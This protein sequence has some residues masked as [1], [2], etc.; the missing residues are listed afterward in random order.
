MYIR[1]YIRTYVH[2]CLFLYA[3]MYVTTVSIIHF[4]SH[5]SIPSRPVLR[6]LHVLKNCADLLC[7]WTR[8]S[9]NVYGVHY[10]S[11]FLITNS[12]SSLTHS[13]I[14]NS[15]SSLTHSLIPNS[16]SSL[17]HSLIPNSLSSLTHSHP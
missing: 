14:P 5:H 11:Q 17:T 4:F 1:T 7:E 15:F 10:P 2:S 6:L 13:L 12:L 9:L 8:L 3:A 16:L